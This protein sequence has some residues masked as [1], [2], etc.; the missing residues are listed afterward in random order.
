MKSPV[1]LTFWGLLA[2]NGIDLYCCYSIFISQGK[3]EI[4]VKVPAQSGSVESMNMQ[5]TWP[6]LEYDSATLIHRVSFSVQ[7]AGFC[8]AP[9]D[10]A[11]NWTRSRHCFFYYYS[12]VCMKF[13]FLPSTLL[14]FPKLSG[15]TLL[16]IDKDVET[17]LFCQALGGFPSLSLP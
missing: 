17:D 16:F 7:I 2:T 3:D 15:C 4:W 9:N 5:I 10:T 12:L 8:L 1:F 13:P 11:S 6:L 14:R